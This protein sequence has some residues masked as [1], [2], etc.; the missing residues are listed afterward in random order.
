MNLNFK[1]YNTPRN[2]FL[3]AALLLLAVLFLLPQADIFGA[4]GKP[5]LAN[6]YL[7]TPISGSE[8][9]ELAKWDLVILGMQVQDTNPEI[10]SSLRALNPKIKIIAYLS[11]MEFP[12]Q[13]YIN[14]ESANGPWHKMLSQINDAW[15]LKDGSGNIHSIWPGNNSFNLTRFCPE[16]NGQKF[17]TFLPAFVKRELIDSGRWDGV[18]F[19]N[20]LESIKDTNNGN[21]DINNDGIIDE[22]TFADSEWKNGVMTMLKETRRLLGPSKIIMVNSSS[23]AHDFINGRL[24][25]TWPHAWLGGWAGSMRDYANLGKEIK[26]SPETIVLNPN[27][28]NTGNQN[29][30]QKVRFGLGSAL[31]GGGYFAFDFGTNDHSQLWWYDEYSVNLGRPIGEP[32]NLLNSRATQYEN[33]VWRRDFENGIVLV[34]STS[35]SQTVNL[36]DATYEKIS[37]FQ[38]PSTNNGQIVNQVILSANDGIFLLRKLEILTGAV[39]GNGS[40]VRV[41]DSWGQT[42]R[43]GFYSYDPRFSGGDEVLIADLNNDGQNETISAGASLVQIFSADGSK[44]SSFNPYTATYNRGIRLAIGDINGDEKKEIITGTKKGGGPHVRIFDLNGKLLNKGFFAFDKN[45]RGGVNVAAG[46]VNGDGSDEIIAGA[47]SGQKPEVKI[48]NA[49]GKEINSTFLAYAIGF[50]GGVN[51]AALD[52]NKDNKDEIITGAGFGGG[53][54]VRIFNITGTPQGKGFFAFDKN[55]RNGV[56]VSSA[57]VDGDG[58]EEII[59]ME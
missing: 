44:I 4:D 37:G 29:D 48:F 46:D 18:F 42:K 3:N 32:K 13:N 17:N 6:Y 5:K 53:P 35:K 45:L 52:L 8:I 59:A 43:P 34:N 12:M 24:Y 2:G 22:K 47:G 19:D 50:R 26:Y 58:E 57:D 23:Y 14:L 25:E 33:G 51:V 11:T 7:K 30:F 9:T 39:F 15:Y 28:N 27:T 36:T 16:I 38:D 40:F 41:F 1:N 55:K 20:A 56:K 54:H 10:F 49:D 21:V 31:M